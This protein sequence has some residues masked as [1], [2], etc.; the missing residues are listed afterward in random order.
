MSRSYGGKADYDQNLFGNSRPPSTRLNENKATTRRSS[1]GLNSAGAA[2]IKASDLQRIKQEAVVKTAADI[3]R[4]RDEKERLKDEQNMK[5]KLR[6]EKMRELERKANKKGKKTEFEIAEERSKEK[7]RAMAA[8]QR[9]KDS[10]VAKLLTSMAE[11][12]IAFNIREQQIEEKHRLDKEE[13]A[14]D[15]KVNMKIELERVE[16]ILQRENDEARKEAK[17]REDRKTINFQIAERER[18]KSMDMEQ[19]RKENM[20]MK[21]QLRRYEEEDRVKAIERQKY[22][23]RS[24]KEVAIA[25]ADAIRRKQELK[26]FEKKEVEKILE[27][28]KQ[29]D[30]ILA[31]R[32]AEEAE[33]EAAKKERLQ[34]MLAI[35]EKAMDDIGTQDELRARRAAEEK[36]RIM[37]KKEKEAALKKKAE[38]ESLMNSRA[39]QQKERDRRAQ[40]EKDLQITEMNQ[41]K[42]LMAKLEARERKE[43]EEKERKAKE[44]RE[45]LQQQINMVRETR[46]LQRAN[47]GLD[48]GPNVRDELKK[49]EFQLNDLRWRMVNELRGQGVNEKYLS[50]MINVDIA[51][52]LRR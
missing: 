42:Q 14:F 46:A 20:A 21:D 45:S 39:A 40:Y 26:D 8:A 28:Q 3:D 36:D 17:R 6:K 34:K 32:E 16:T 18:Q 52:M 44:F 10:D 2:V 15:K 48:A 24:K 41:S 47:Q 22:K 11:R 19:K 23:D 4:E 49:E 29:R 1:N 27:Y 38:I 35:Q 51:K 30:Q 50:E 37:R 43:K 31:E 7:K 12:A 9:E 25:N 33:R 5:S 13:I